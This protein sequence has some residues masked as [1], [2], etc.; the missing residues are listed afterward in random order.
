MR[1]IQLPILRSGLLLCSLAAALVA[2][3]D[4]PRRS[5]EGFTL[6]NPTPPDLMREL[7]TDRPDQTESAYTVDAGHFQVEMD[8]VNYTY[9]RDTTGGADSRTRAWSFAPINLKLGLL[10]RVDVQLM[11]EPHARIRFE[12]RVAR[13]KET[14]SGFGDVATRVKVNLWGNDGGKTALAVMPF[15]KWPLPASSLRNGKTEGGIIVPLAIELAEGWSMS[16]MTESDF[17][18]DGGG[19]Y[20]AEWVNSITVGHEFTKR[21]SGYC[22]FFTVTS[23]APGFKWQGQVDVGLTYAIADNVQLDVG[24]NFGVTRS[25]PD[26]QPFIGLS[27]RF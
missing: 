18:S 7:S 11:L 24:C 3:D 13:T 23:R 9:D 19:G 1:T 5:K 14:L 16:V 6:W 10:N 15:V 25:A 17:V 26:Y 21:L 2:A 27:R 8:F 20:D 22:E 4:K 12:D